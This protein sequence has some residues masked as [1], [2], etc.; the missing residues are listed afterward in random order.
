MIYYSMCHE[1]MDGGYTDGEVLFSPALDDYYQVGKNFALEG[2]M[3][4]VTLDKRVRNLK[5]DFFLTTVGAFFVSKELKNILEE[6]N[7]KVE[8]ALASVRYFNGKP[9]DKEYFLIHANETCK[10]LD[11]QLSEY[12]GKSMVLNKIQAGELS[13]DYKVRGIKRMC[14]DEA[15]A[16]GLDFFFVGGV[17]WIDPIASERLVSKI[18]KKKLFIKFNAIG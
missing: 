15:E 5:S 1:V 12:S 3:V 10:C 2:L 17:I 11:Y 8:F 18:K 14:V 7:A 16:G 9:S 6:V 4:S 13:A